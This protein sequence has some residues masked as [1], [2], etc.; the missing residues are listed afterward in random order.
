[1]A[2]LV[3]PFPFF[4]VDD[5]LPFANISDD[6]LLDI[7]NGD[8]PYKFELSDL[9]KMQF[10]N[11]VWNDEAQLQEHDPDNFILG[12]LGILNPVSMYH[13][14]C[15]QLGNQL[16]DTNSNSMSVMSYNINSIPDHFHDFLDQCLSPIDHDF[17]IMGFCETKLSGDIHHLYSIPN[18]NA[19][20]NSLNRNKGG[21][22]IY[23]SERL[24]SSARPDLSMLEDFLETI[25][26]DVKI[27]NI[28]YVIGQVYR[29]PHTNFRSFMEK[30]E[31]II[32][33]IKQEGKTCILL[34]DYNIDLFKAKNYSRNLITMFNSKFYFNSITKP[35]R[36]TSKTATLIDHIWVNNLKDLIMSGILYF[37]LSDHFPIFS[38]FKLHAS[39]NNI[40]RKTTEYREFNDAN[41]EDF[42]LH[43]TEVDWDIV[44]ASENPNVAYNNFSTI[45]NASF[46]KY[47]PVKIKHI[48]VK[49]LEKPYITAQIKE[50]IAEKNRLQRKFSKWPITYGN[51]FRRVRN[52]LTRIIRNAKST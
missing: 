2:T 45:F 24:A 12:S 51:Q 48:K 40:K 22:A 43:L 37:N 41:I 31:M 35:T 13:F 5:Q 29:R 4:N 3:D 33:K 18:Y 26:V 47:F 34:G 38:K 42:K 30:M 28:V 9:E 25:F 46:N 11:I 52:E 44:L 23:V 50:L 16:N 27:N 17:N 14:P 49:S 10:N 15:A 1:M 6:E 19:Y 8:L 36:V 7:L 21:V 39:L 32:D 20:F